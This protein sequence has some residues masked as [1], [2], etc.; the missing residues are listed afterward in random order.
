MMTKVQ[1]FLIFFPWWKLP[2]SFGQW[3][4]VQFWPVIWCPVLPQDKNI[5]FIS[6]SFLSCF[7]SLL[8]SFLFFPYFLYF[9]FTLFLS[10]PFFLSLFFLLSFLFFVS[11]SFFFSHFFLQYN[12][13]FLCFFCSFL[14]NNSVYF[15]FQFYLLF[16]FFFSIFFL[17]F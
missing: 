16:C 11:F 13:F 9:I 15:F 6:F 3:Y 1:T 5:V 8:N 10:L 4:D 12:L 7:L 17:F 2:D 14:N